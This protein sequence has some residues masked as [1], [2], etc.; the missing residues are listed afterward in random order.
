M[1]SFELNGKPTLSQLNQNLKRI[2]ALKYKG[3]YLTDSNQI[4]EY[5]I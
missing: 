3:D 4:N 1:G 2:T 5:H